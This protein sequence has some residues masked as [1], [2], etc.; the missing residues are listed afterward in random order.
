V[1]PL[2][3]VPAGQGS[4]LADCAAWAN[5]ST[6]QGVQV[7]SWPPGDDRPGLRQQSSLN[8]GAR[9]Q[10]WWA[11]NPVCIATRMTMWLSKQITYGQGLQPSGVE[12][13]PGSHTSTAKDETATT[14]VGVQYNL[15]LSPS[16][17]V[18]MLSPVQL[19]GLRA[20]ITYL[21]HLVEPVAPLVVVLGGQASHL[22]EPS[23]GANVSTGHTSHLAFTPPAENW[24]GL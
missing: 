23:L 9:R 2:V 1:A 18:H 17:A 15:L 21:P 12:P 20:L 8:H 3:V 10:V 4:H 19:P 16:M 7:T 6:G 14:F 24:P 11:W 5:V 22:S 13:K